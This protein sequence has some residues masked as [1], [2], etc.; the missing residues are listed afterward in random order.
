[1]RGWLPSAALAALTVA[2]IW[3]SA[4]GVFRLRQ[5]VSESQD[6]YRL[7]TIGW[8][9]ESDLEVQEQQS[10]LASLDAS[11]QADENVLGTLQ[12]LRQINAPEPVNQS[13]LDFETSWGVYAQTR[14]NDA[15]LAALGKLRA[16]KHALK[17]HARA[18]ASR[19]DW[20]LKHCLRDLAAFVTAIF[21]ILAALMKI[22][23]ARARA[24]LSS[25]QE[26]E[27]AQEMDQRR[28]AILEMVVTHAPLARTLT[29]IAELPSRYQNG[30]G[31]ALWSIADDAL[32]Y[33]V[34]AGLSVPVAN[35]LR[36]RSFERV[37]GTLKLDADALR[38]IGELALRAD[39]TQTIVPLRN[40]T[41]DAIGLLLLF[42]PV[43]AP[44]GEIP[45]RLSSQMA[46]L[47]SLTIENALLYERLAFQAQHDV[48][49][50]LPN[51]L[52]FQDRVQQAIL[53]AQRNRRKVAVLWFDLD[54]F[55]QIND[56]LGH[57]IGDEL[58][59]EFAERIKGSLRKSDTAAR[60]GGDEFVVLVA[61]LDGASDFRVVVE[62]L[63]KR[64]R[65]SMTVSGR[66]L[67]ISA[68]AGVSV[69]PDHGA[70]PAE[71]MRNADLAMYEAKRAGRD[72][73]H[74]FQKELSDSLGRRL[75]V[76]QEL[77]TAIEKGEFRLEY[78]PLIGRRD[79]LAG[80]EALLRW[81]SRK[82]GS[83][84][85]AEFI[86][87]AEDSGLILRIGEWVTRTACR[88][89]SRWLEEG[90]QV[91]SIAV[92]AS[93]L[94]FA[95]ANFSEMICAALAESGFPPSKLEIEV[96]ETALVGNL[97]SALQKIAH[98]R[99]LGIRFAIDDFGT[100][101]SSLNQLRTLPV[102]SVKVD[103][104][105]IKDLER[106]SSDSITLVKGIIGMAHN[107]RLDV[108]AEGVETEGQ[109]AILRSLGCDISQGFYLHR[110]LTV[111]A[112]EELMRVHAAKQHPAL[113]DALMREPLLELVPESNLV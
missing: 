16:L 58:L 103:R 86:P 36:S 111:T 89:G 72:T 105:F 101:Y 84:S 68:S 78:Q 41:G 65:L 81:N 69:Y 109:L 4:M 15:F 32:L 95:A 19:V 44:I 88:D 7:D 9:I 91:P 47:A 22:R 60:I 108:V 39:L 106:S 63:M 49:T 92:N 51:R 20:T 102:D 70:E 80:F 12:H 62:K 98:L 110:P 24:L 55:K 8:Q 43:R 13:I 112:A 33:Q 99:G 53:R 100:G 52:L 3:G 5:A 83:V 90:L 76:E 87:I 26:L 54:R 45:Q 18:Q 34:S 35:A 10:R 97:K 17:D 28:V 64:I 96:T 46:Q 59:C 93:G 11:R 1:M 21:I 104:S 66:E 42:A 61:D 40:V 107:L 27:H 79:E 85:P 94:Q 37:E 57:R 74:V 113:C 73:F 50:G 30:A 23:R 14:G 25:N 75:E 71:L 6:L 67:S 29:A 48:L 38:E 77:K 56:T 31:A 2:A 82:L